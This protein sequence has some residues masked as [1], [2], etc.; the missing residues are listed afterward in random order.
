[1][2]KLL[3]LT[4]S[5]LAVFLLAP[6]VLAQES[7][8]IDV[9]AMLYSTNEA[10]TVDNINWPRDRNATELRM[11]TNYG[12]IIGVDLRWTD[13]D[14]IS[15]SKKVAQAAHNKFT[16]QKVV[17]VPVSGAFK[18]VYRNPFPTKIIDG[19]DRTSIIARGDPVDPSIP[20]DVMIYTHAKTWTGID[21]ERWTYGFANEEHEDYVILE[22]LFTNTSGETRKD[23]YFGFTAQTNGHAQYPADIWGT[24]YGATYQKYAAGDL[25]ADSMRVWYS[26]DADD[27]GHNADTRGEPEPIWG[28]F[29][30]PQF[31]SHVVLH[32]DKSTTDESDDPAKPIKAGWSQRELSPNLAETTHDEVYKFLSEGWDMANPSSYARTVNSD[33]VEVPGGMYRQLRPDIDTRTF[34]SVTEQEKSGFFSF[35]PYQM[36]PGED[37]RIVLAFAGGSIPHRLA[38]DAGRAY[39]NGFTQQRPSVPLPYDVFDLDGNL[40]AEEGQLLTIDQKDAILDLGRELALRNAGKAIRTWKNGNVRSGQGSFD[41]P[42]APATPSLTGISEPDQI[43]LEWGSEAEQDSRAGTI[44]AY[45]IYRDYKRPRSITLPTDTTF[46]LIEEVPATTHEYVDTEVIRGEDYYYYIVA[47]SDQGVESSRFLNRTGTSATRTDEALSPTRAPDPDWQEN[48]VV[49]PNPYHVRGSQKYPGKRLNF[50]NLPP[51]ANIKIYT[52]TGDLVQS[53]RHDASTGDEDWERQETFSTMEVVSGVYFFI[54]EE[55]NG[56][57][58]SP[59]GNKAMGK[60]VVIK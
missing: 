56:P 38:I 18:R 29:R 10:L 50:L 7:R 45:R 2:N 59:T 23:V 28:N 4:T 34:D 3:Q 24:Y 33:G 17:V 48:V 11:L 41:I 20:S 27:K 40:I 37:V 30:E 22:Y 19:T 58:G 60:F 52:M 46:T 13:E 1:M 25:S 54:V 12:V 16:D 43:R 14:G 36:A 55:L 44:T 42:L 53:L 15:Y 8:Q 6:G 57:N 32:A 9:G 31:M 39:Q 49:V 35:G 5:L 21:I 47:V 51:Y 26:W